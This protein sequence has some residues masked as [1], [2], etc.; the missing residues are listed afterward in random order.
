MSL[1]SLTE[2][3]GAPVSRAFSRPILVPVIHTEEEFDWSAP[4]SRAA[5]GTGHIAALADAQAIFEAHKLI[6]LYM[7]SHP[8]ACDPAAQALLRPWADQGRAVI[9]AH[10]HPWVC[11]PDEE[12]VTAANSYP[13]NLSPDLER[14]KLAQLTET[15]ARGFQRRPTAYLAGRYGLGPHTAQHLAALG[16]R[17][18][19]S[20]SPSFDFTAQHGPDYR[21]WP[22][23]AH[24]NAAETRLLHIPHASGYAGFLCEG[25]RRPAGF[26]QTA[27]GRALKLPAVLARIGAIQRGRISP[28]GMPLALMQAV[29]KALIADGVRLITFSF[30]SPSLAPGHTPYVRSDQDRTAFLGRIAGFCD[31]FCRD[32]EGIG[33]HPDRIYQRALAWR[34]TGA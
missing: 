26:D 21:D 25:G 29:A 6:P 16:Y 32:C 8:V 5:R 2:Q 19:F 3:I 33:L 11:P 20:P 10:L 17:L 7:L 14:A 23:H 31:W 13:G 15:I 24:F 4:F 30:H 34:R 22:V 12:A 18:D 1:A 28:E 9:G 27:L